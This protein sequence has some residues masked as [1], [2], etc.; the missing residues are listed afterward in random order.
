[1]KHALSALALAGAAA[2]AHADAS[3]TV[4]LTWDDDP[5][6]I[7]VG[8]NDTP[9]FI[10][11]GEQFAFRVTASNEFASGNSD[12]RALSVLASVTQIDG[13]SLGSNVFYATVGFRDYPDNDGNP[14]VDTLN[15]DWE[16][17]HGLNA[18]MQFYFPPDTV[19]IINF[20]P[21]TGFDDGTIDAT[22]ADFL[23]KIPQFVDAEPIDLDA[24]IGT[25]YFGL[26]NGSLSEPV[27]LCLPDLNEDDVLNNSDI[28]IF[29]NAF[30]AMDP[31][32]DVNGDG[33]WNN[34]D[35]NIFVTA[36]LAGCE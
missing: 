20:N 33:F 31:Y 30:L 18:R 28:N 23:A 14:I 8:I 32:A 24:E 22:I 21:L 26:P 5:T 3:F 4:Y 34:S 9:V 25:L 27:A 29:V 16:Y 19:S 15:I 11:E 6:T 1:M 7:F 12:G 17:D 2:A 35:V 36:F 13:P 10:D